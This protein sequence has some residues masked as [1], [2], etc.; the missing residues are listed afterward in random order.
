MKALAAEI[1]RNFSNR[2]SAL[3]INVR[4]FTGDMSL[5]KQ[6]LAATQVSS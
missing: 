2:L 4:E 3:G 1:V 5:T 6:E